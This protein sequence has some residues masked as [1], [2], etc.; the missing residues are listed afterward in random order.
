MCVHRAVC[1]R[2]HVSLKAE[3]GSL[4]IKIQKE[5]MSTTSL[6]SVVLC[7]GVQPQNL[8]LEGCL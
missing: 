7:E 2:I 6:A 5:N 3:C 1:V 8:R 4:C